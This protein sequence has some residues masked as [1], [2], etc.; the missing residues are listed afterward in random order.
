MRSILFIVIGIFLASLDHAWAESLNPV[1]TYEQKAVI[2]ALR[3][4]AQ[5]LQD[6]SEKANDLLRQLEQKALGDHSQPRG[7]IAVEASESQARIVNGV[8]TAEYPSVGALLKIKEGIPSFW[9]TGTLIGNSTFLT[10]AHCVVERLDKVQ[11]QVY[12]QHGGRFSVKS[13]ETPPGYSFPQ[14]DIAV[15][16]LASPVTGIKPSEINKI[17]AIPFGTS[18]TI[19]GF[20]RRGGK[21][22]NYGIKQVGSILTSDC[23]DAGSEFSNSNFICWKYDLRVELPGENSNTC[24]GDSGGPLFSRVN[25]NNIPVVVGVTSGGK[26]DTCLSGDKSYDTQVSAYSRWIIEQSERARVLGGNASLPYV[27]SESVVVMASD[28]KLLVRGDH[29]D[30]TFN[31]PENASMLRVALN[32]ED[33]GQ[34]VNDFDLAVSP[35]NESNREGS[36]CRDVGPGVFSFCELSSPSAGKWQIRVFSKSG[37]GQFQVVS[38]IFLK[39]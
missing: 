10:A 9:C 7:Q 2:R 31:V 17:N 16:G 18:G 28:E 25:T 20:G 34:G 32:G 24:N 19:V 15:L 11:Y 27:G 14:K 23:R 12:F 33:Q 5:I 37:A 22:Y 35:D 6:N 13:I 1:E 26:K 36:S 38:S 21:D 8:P 3:E 39:N 4:K 30:F 29:K